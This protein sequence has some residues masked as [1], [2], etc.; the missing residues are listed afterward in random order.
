MSPAWGASPWD[1][2]IQPREGVSAFRTRQLAP[3]PADPLGSTQLLPSNRAS[4]DRA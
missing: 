1:R 2:M 3:Q 4:Q